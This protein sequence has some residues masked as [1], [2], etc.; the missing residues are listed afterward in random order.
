[1]SK[2][3]VEARPKISRAEFTMFLDEMKSFAIPTHQNLLQNFK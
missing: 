3:W 2:Y 1:M